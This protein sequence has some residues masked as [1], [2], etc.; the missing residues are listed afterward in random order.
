MTLRDHVTPCINDAPIKGGN[1]IILYQCDN[2]ITGREAL[3]Y[4]HLYQD[5]AYKKL[6]G[7]ETIKVYGEIYQINGHRQ[8]H[9][10][11]SRNSTG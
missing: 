1:R 8:A 10:Q 4:P 2:L 3:H 9:I 5:Q 7:Y 11:K 6:Y